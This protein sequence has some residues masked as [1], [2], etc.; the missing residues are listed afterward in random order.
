MI[1]MEQNFSQKKNH[2]NKL[3]FLGK[4]KRKKDYNY[5][6]NWKQKMKILQKINYSTKIS[7]QGVILIIPKRNKLKIQKLKIKLIMINHKKTITHNSYKPKHL[8]S[9]NSFFYQKKITSKHQMKLYLLKNL[10]I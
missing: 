6:N 5:N 7:I 2:M 9:I 3:I 4:S 1:S 10:M 8:S